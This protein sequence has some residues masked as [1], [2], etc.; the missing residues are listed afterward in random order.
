MH[1]KA[2]QGQ[3]HI[4]LKE[5]RDIRPQILCFARSFYPFV[6]V[7]SIVETILALLSPS[8]GG[9]SAVP[10]DILLICM[11]FKKRLLAISAAS[12]AV[13]IARPLAFKVIS[14]ALL[15]EKLV[16]IAKT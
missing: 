10:M 8:L 6:S 3:L 2:C 5:K 15:A 13:V 11:S 9:I 16:M 14:L 4:L 7:I 12:T 1:K